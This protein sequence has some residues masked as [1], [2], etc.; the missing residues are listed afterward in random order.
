M[1]QFLSWSFST[2]KIYCS[3]TAPHLTKMVC[4]L[5]TYCKEDYKNMVK[6]CI[7]LIYHIFSTTSHVKTTK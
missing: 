5:Q 3:Q 1:W 4:N 6:W 2:T 7:C